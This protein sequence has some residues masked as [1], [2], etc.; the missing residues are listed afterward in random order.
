MFG[1]VSITHIAC[2]ACPDIAPTIDYVAIKQLLYC[3]SHA[4]WDYCIW[5]GSRGEYSA[6]LR[7]ILYMS[8]DLPPNAT[9]PIV[10]YARGGTC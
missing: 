5:A 4:L 3:M 9:T 2:C 1:L 7:F 10:W 8:L 6:Q